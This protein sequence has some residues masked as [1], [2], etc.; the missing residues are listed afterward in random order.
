MKRI[1]ERILT[2]LK[3]RALAIMI[4]L[5]FMLYAVLLLL[6]F[7]YLYKDKL[8]LKDNEIENVTEELIVARNNEC[9]CRFEE[10]DKGFIIDG[11]YY[12]YKEDYYGKN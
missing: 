5:G 2:I 1:K 12:E 7:G 10:T 11:A 6:I 4:V 8:D 9:K 3:E